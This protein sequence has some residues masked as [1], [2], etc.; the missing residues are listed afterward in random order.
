MAWIQLSNGLFTE[1]DTE[2]A[3][4]LL[5]MGSWS[6]S[7]RNKDKQTGG[8]AGRYIDGKYVYMHVYI[9][10][11]MGLQGKVD[12]KDR[13]RLNNKRENLREATFSEDRRNRKV[14]KNNTSGY[15]G[16]YFKK[17]QPEHR[18]HHDKWYAA[19]SYNGIQMQSGYFDTIEEAIEERKRMIKLYYGE[20]IDPDE[21][22]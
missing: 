21:I 1:V 11:K 12:H 14:F 20:F 17:A 18:R 15:K 16:V 9:A 4:E 5:G 19:I 22:D 10:R 3:I 2:D 6:Y 13:N 8:Y 7:A